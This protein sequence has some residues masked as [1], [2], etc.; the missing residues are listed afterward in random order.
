M[1]APPACLENSLY[2][3]QF[4][5]YGV[6]VIVF[7]L[8]EPKGLVGIWLRIRGFFENWPYKYKGM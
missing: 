6:F 7:L 3:V 4:G 1:Q 2:A 8:Y 5:I